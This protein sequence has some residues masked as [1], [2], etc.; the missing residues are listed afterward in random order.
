RDLTVLSGSRKIT[1]DK[2][3]WT[4]KPVEVEDADEY[5]HGTTLVFS[6]EPWDLKTVEPHAVFSGLQ[7]LVDGKRCVRQEF[8]SKVVTHYPE[9]GC[10]IEVCSSENLSEWHKHFQDFHYRSETIVNFHGQ[11][12]VFDYNSVDE[13]GL[14]FLVDMT[15]EPTGIRLMLPARTQLIANESLEKLKKAIEVE[16][17]RYIQKRGHHK[18]PFKDYQRARELGIVLP[19]ATPVFVAGTISGDI[20]EPV[21]VSKPDNFPLAK[22]CRVSEKITKRETHNTD[23]HLL[24]ALG[25]FKDPFV[26]VRIDPE[27]DGY[28]WAKLPVVESIKVIFGKKLGDGDLFSMPVIAVDSIHI[29]VH[30]SDGRVFRSDVPM[31]IKDVAKKTPMW[32]D[33]TVYLTTDSRTKLSTSDVWFHCGGWNDDGDTYDTQL[34]SFEEELAMFWSGI[35]GPGEYLYPKLV[36]AMWGINLEW[37][38]VT[39]DADGMLRIVLKDGTEQVY[40]PS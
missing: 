34:Q 31:A 4:G 17:Y 23:V 13:S 39:F 38:K 35:F 26:P 9:L 29:I 3:G 16:S 32:Y 37:Q 2:N 19:E 7:V 14:R 20:L 22:C 40:P 21:E 5:V 27:Y 18:M 33:H 8:C 36:S 6:D 10:R 24:A 28:S 11:V 30:T 15:G 1:I 12:V 25:T